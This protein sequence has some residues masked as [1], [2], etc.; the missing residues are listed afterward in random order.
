MKELSRATLPAN[1]VVWLDMLR[2]MSAQLVLLGHLSLFRSDTAVLHP[3][4]IQTIAVVIFYILSGF[5]IFHTIFNKLPLASYT[6]TSFFIDRFCRIYPAYVAALLFVVVID[7]LHMHFYP[8][9]YAEHGYRYRVV[10]FISNLFFLQKI[11][12]HQGSFGTADQLWSLPPE[13]WMY[14]FSGYAVFTL[15]R[16]ATLSWR[17]LAIL[18][19]LGFAPVSFLFHGNPITGVGMSALW[20]FGG[21]ACVFHRFLPVDIHRGNIR[22]LLTYFLIM[23]LGCA[24][25]R[26]IST[27][28]GYDMLGAFNLAGAFLCSVWL[29]HSAGC[30]VLSRPYVRSASRF[31]A[32]YSFSLY[33]T[34]YSLCLLLGYSLPKVLIWLIYNLVAIAFGHVFE[35]NHRQL[36]T[37]LKAAVAGRGRT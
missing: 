21:I 36:A 19:L 32:G 22:I 14:M 20:I 24:C 4:A 31:L 27:D 15:S 1:T 2:G 7:A 5:L 35:R 16:K 33:L 26:Y 37:R 23:F 18:S 6:F 13:W 12:L 9:P 10:T 8:L 17:H 29:T 30:D 3:A 11:N 28:Y 25:Y 34:H